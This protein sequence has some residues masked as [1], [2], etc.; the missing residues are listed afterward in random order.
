MH[1]EGM[2]KE[3]KAE[4]MQWRGLGGEWVKFAYFMLYLSNDGCKWVNE[5]AYGIHD[6]N[7]YEI[8]ESVEIIRWILV[9]SEIWD[10][11][12]ELRMSKCMFSNGVVVW[13]NKGVVRRI[14]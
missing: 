8:H 11:I 14:D 6:G 12:K 2:H 1:V 10:M 9:R 5:N 4:L 7:A 3:R 13:P